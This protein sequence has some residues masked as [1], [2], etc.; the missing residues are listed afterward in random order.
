MSGQFFCLPMQIMLNAFYRILN[1]KCVLPHFVLNANHSLLC[2][3]I[4]LDYQVFTYQAV[5]YDGRPHFCFVRP[6]WWLGH[7]HVLSRKQNYLQPCN[8]F[9]FEMYWNCIKLQQLVCR[10][11]SL[12]AFSLTSYYSQTVIFPNS[13]HPWDTNLD[14]GLM[15]GIQKTNNHRL[16]NVTFNN[17]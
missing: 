11:V 13:F 14:P 8:P 17:F 5:L 10:V 2:I 16:Y 15:T 7:T 4:A 9:W 12:C 1:A 6:K 3:D